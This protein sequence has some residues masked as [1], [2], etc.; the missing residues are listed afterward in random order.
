[1]KFK[2]I[3]VKNTLSQHQAN[4]L[5]HYFRTHR[6]LVGVGDGSDYTGINKIHIHTQWVRDL[7][8]VLEIK[9]V[10]EIRKYSDQIVYPEMCQITEWPIGGVQ[11]PHLDSYS[12]YD[13]TH[14]MEEENPSREWTAIVY[15]NQ[16]YKGGRTYFPTS[17]YNA[18]EYFHQQESC[19][20]LLFQG[21]YH[22]HGVEKVRGNNRYTIAIW[23]STDENRIISDRRTTDLS[24]DNVTI[25]K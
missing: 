3:S 22:P 14:N 18:V 4:K 2:T 12:S 10:G 8:S 11:E 5:I 25:K 6:N 7:L 24:V 15:L 19:E 1:M 16:D 21:I 23:F 20:M 13:L 9:A 17:E